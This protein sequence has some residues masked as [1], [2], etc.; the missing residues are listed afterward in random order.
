MSLD[1]R[2]T[3]A[4]RV[5][6]TSFPGIPTAVVWRAATLSIGFSLVSCITCM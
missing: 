2:Y 3:P 5:P 4:K 6:V 1:P